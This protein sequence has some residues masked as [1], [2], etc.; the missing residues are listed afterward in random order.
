MVHRQNDLAKVQIYFIVVH[1]SEMIE[2]D[3]IWQRRPFTFPLFLPFLSSMYVKS[4]LRKYAVD[5]KVLWQVNIV[6]VP[7]ILLPC[8]G[9]WAKNYTV[10]DAY[11]CLIVGH[12]F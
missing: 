5:L 10:I 11:I 12:Y 2:A 9:V 8:F 6:R 3:V 1:V 7:F 4:P